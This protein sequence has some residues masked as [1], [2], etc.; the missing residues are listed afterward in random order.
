MDFFERHLRLLSAKYAR[1][2]YRYP[3]WFVTIPLV[4]GV[5][6]STGL[7]FLNKIDSAMYLY[8]PVNGAGKYELA[9]FQSLWPEKS[10]GFAPS[11]M[12]TSKGQC[13]LYVTAKDGGNIFTDEMLQAI[14]KVN[15]YV[16]EKIQVTDGGKILKYEDVCAKARNACYLNP[17]VHMIKAFRQSPDVINVQLTYPK[18]TVGNQAIYLA[19]TLSGV[20]INKT[21]GNIQ[22]AKA[23]MLVYPLEFSSSDDKFRK[24]L[25]Q[26]EFEKR[27]TSY[28]DPLLSL[29]VFHDTALD[30]ELNRNAQVLAPRLLPCFVL[31]LVFSALST[32][33]LTK[34]GNRVFLKAASYSPLVAIGG[35]LGA[36]LGVASSMG[37]TTYVGFPYNKVVAIMPFLIVSV[38]IDN[39]F[40]MIAALAAA[41]RNLSV[42]DRI[43]EAISEASV[44]IFLTVATDALSFGVGCITDFPA[45][46]IF[47]VYTCSAIIVTFIYQ[48]T[49]LFGLL[50]YEARRENRMNRQS[51]E[52][53][54]S[55]VATLMSK[56]RPFTKT[57]VAASCQKKNRVK[58]ETKDKIVLPNHSRNKPDDKV[59]EVEFFNSFF[60]GQYATFI[61]SKHARFLIALLFVLY[62]VASVY[63]CMGIR[64]GLEPYKLLPFGSYVGAYYQK[65]EKYMWT[66]GIQMQV[67]VSK[68]GNLADYKQREKIISLVRM[69]AESRH[70]IGLEGVECWLIDYLRFL[71]GQMGIDIDDLNNNSFYDYALLFLNMPNN[72]A[73]R[74]DIIW[75]ENSSNDRIK[76]FRFLVGLKAFNS[77]V[78][79]RETVA[80]MRRIASD[81]AALN[82]TTFNKLWPYVDQYDAILP[83]IIQECGFGIMCMILLALFLIPKAICSLWVTFAILSVDLGV[84]GFMTLWGLNMDTVSMITIVM[85]IGFSVDFSAHIAYAYSIQTA[86]KP[87]QRI[88]YALGQLAWPVIQGGIST[89]LGVL[90][91]ADLGSY[92][93][94]SFFKTV[95]LVVTLG[96]IHALLFLPLF[97]TLSG[98]LS[99]KYKSHCCH[100][101]KRDGSVPEDIERQASSNC[102]KPE[103]HKVINGTLGMGI[104]SCILLWIDAARKVQSPQVQQAKIK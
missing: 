86:A 43:V 79:Q 55:L 61:M 104:V 80:D 46:Q 28:E 23:W 57:L 83:N 56:I 71:G 88:R 81:N 85:S 35:V 41:D 82:V 75:E 5:A 14:V 93:I 95:F 2:V 19:S 44:S 42:E 52:Y 94:K 48:L 31:L 96:L 34:R 102:N 67:A 77:T 70:G 54:S 63:G 20:E 45:V 65:M 40:L 18:M 25:W 58:G 98:E 64:E 7:L 30:D 84:I 101:R 66:Y 97:L 12:Y 49:F 21:T 76:A 13:F 78:S 11:R 10:D 37:L 3:A 51:D 33:Q 69:L 22:S 8:T 15:S 39:T 50:V 26:A 1:V 90:L 36:C 72:E 29:S 59:E 4:V 32:I 6:L 38:R 62:A 73:Y 99:E 17:L 53:R 47:C 74:K 24:D 103:N 60:S 100:I 91:L 16:I 92:M 87:I 89:L 68:P 9:V 27:M